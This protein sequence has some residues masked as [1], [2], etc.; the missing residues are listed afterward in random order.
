LIKKIDLSGNHY[1]MGY[2]HGRQVIDLRA[3]LLQT[4]DHRL[5][6]LQKVDIETRPYAVEIYD[7]WETTAHTT[8]EMLRGIADAL[9]LEWQ[10]FFR[11][12]IASYLLDRRLN[13]L[14]DEQGCTVWAAAYPA[15]RGGSPMLVKNRDYWLDHQGLQILASAHPSQGYQYT[16]LTSAGS[17]GV[18]SSGMNEVGLA[19]ADT[20]VVSH[21][22]GPGLARYTVM[23]DLLE[24]HSSS[25]S[26]MDYLRG[27]QH[28]GNG[29]IVLLDT[30]GE[31]A[32][33]E[34][35]HKVSGTVLPKNGY[36]V[37]TNHF[38][39]SELAL[40]WEPCGPEEIHGNSP[41]MYARVSQ[42]LHDA[43]GL[44][45][46]SWAK[47]LMSS[48]GDPL[49]AIC[50]HQEAG[51]RSVTISSIIFLP[52]G[53]MLYLAAGNPCQSKFHKWSLNNNNK[54]YAD[55]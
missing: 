41:K 25:Q 21:D 52:Q 31:M 28:I 45:D 6:T 7:L 16:Y 26:A 55:Q 30:Q 50:R 15:T 44:V 8:L 35:G 27:I 2:Q 10:P 13:P 20:H 48:H 5:N 19:V 39:T 43:Q 23:M 22:I 49:K 11:Y 4:I 34:T 46:I 24:H 54:T 17:P 14:S 9:E 37:S 40:R 47:A 53:N 18:F 42:S 32:V 51:P 1:E 36:V 33:C 29:T 3:H 12:T 38:V